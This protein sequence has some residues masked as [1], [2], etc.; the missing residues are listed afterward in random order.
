MAL[1]QVAGDQ[2]ELDGRA[3]LQMLQQVEQ[4]ERVLAAGDPDQDPVAGLDQP[5]VRDGAT[6]VAQEPLLQHRHAARLPRNRAPLQQ[7]RRPKAG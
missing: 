4:G 5:E 2:R 1:V 3:A 7:S 6:G